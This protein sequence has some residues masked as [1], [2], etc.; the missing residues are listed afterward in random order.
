MAILNFIGFETGDSL[1]A[2][3]TSGTFSVQ[4]TTKR[5]GSYSLRINPS[6]AA[7]S[8]QFRGLAATGA[9][10][11][12]FALSTAYITFYLRVGALPGAT[13]RV[14]EF[15]DGTNAIMR[16]RMDSSGN[17]FLST[18]AGVDSSIAATL[19]ADG[20]WH[21]VD[22]KAIQNGTATLSIDGGGAVSK[23][24]GANSTINAFMFGS[25]NSETKDFYFDDAVVSSTG[26]PTTP[27]VVILLPDGD[28]FYQ[29]SFTHGT[30]A[31]Q[32][33]DEVPNDGDTSRW[34]AVGA[35]N[36]RTVTLTNPSSSGLGLI[37]AV[38]GIAIVEATPASRTGVIRLRSNTTDSSSSGLSVG[39]GY[40]AQ[41]RLLETDPDT[42]AAWLE[43]AV[44]A[45]EVGVQTTATNN[46]R[47]SAL[48]V[49]VLSE[50]P[51]TVVPS[52]LSLTITTY[53]PSI[54]GEK[55]IVP[56][57]LALILTEFA[58]VVTAPALVN[59]QL[60]LLVLTAFAP[61]VTGT[62]SVNPTTA[63]L[64]IVTYAPSVSNRGY[65]GN[66]RR[67]GRSITTQS[68]GSITTSR[69]FGGSITTRRL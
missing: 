6:S 28:G 49:M 54:E 8:W 35:N 64:H 43:A 11:S 20:L 39:P 29:T 31:W 63:H 56:G 13:V 36:E 50:G 62:L 45:L 42:S 40:I 41:S 19:T 37:D 25:T 47:C 44:D 55:L 10:N 1:E 68:Q 32:D 15:N 24:G 4:S 18:A 7:G 34:T 52:T 51:V 66:R 69:G 23:T 17:I 67:N 27:Q 58:P 57:V 53:A 22:F 2:G 14:C 38:K 16:V 5:S 33:V 26:F 59:P 21:R 61:T 9:G 65:S 48:Y 46:W 30:P 3:S 60:L 12:S